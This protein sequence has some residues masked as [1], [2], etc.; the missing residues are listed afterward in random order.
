[1]WNGEKSG[2]LIITA[3][4][5]LNVMVILYTSLVHIHFPKRLAPEQDAK[6]SGLGHGCQYRSGR[7]RVCVWICMCTCDA[8]SRAGRGEMS[9]W[10]YLANAAASDKS[11]IS[12]ILR[13][14]PRGPCRTPPLQIYPA[15]TTQRHNSPSLIAHPLLPS[16]LP[17]PKPSRHPHLFA[18]PPSSGHSRQYASLTLANQ[19]FTLDAQMW[20]RKK[21]EKRKSKRW[22]GGG[23]G[24]EIGK[25]NI[26]YFTLFRGLC[27]YWAHINS[28]GPFMHFNSV[29]LSRRSTYFICNPLYLQP[30]ILACQGK[31]QGRKGGKGRKKEETHTHTRA[32]HTHKGRMWISKY[33][34]ELL[35]S[36][37]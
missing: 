11:F 5:T 15:G 21:R 12:L 18:L 6:F 25:K 3:R 1:M 35:C 33:I 31:W 28:S 36:S 8:S 34:P 32:W 17:R 9:L 30:E 2:R 23:E 7:T 37:E 13:E 19:R 26:L 24:R 14:R 20:L 29:A 27:W 10:L 22:Y 4:H 16:S